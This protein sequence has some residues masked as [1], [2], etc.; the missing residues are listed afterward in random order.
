MGDENA[1]GLANVRDSWC[2]C[3]KSGPPDAELTFTRRA[4]AVYSTKLIRFV[5]AS[6]PMQHGDGRFFF[7]GA[8]GIIP[9][10][11]CGISKRTGR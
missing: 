2:R 8:C 3:R 9:P 4:H 7:F 11:Y 5:R 10:V 1:S 6:K